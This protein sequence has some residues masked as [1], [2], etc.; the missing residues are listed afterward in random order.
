MSHPRH[1]YLYQRFATD[2][3]KRTPFA[4]EFRHRV[5]PFTQTR[6]SWETRA[7]FFDTN[8]WEENTVSWSIY[9]EV[10]E[11]MMVRMPRS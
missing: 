3:H 4:K 8:P 10:D 11:V 9:E 2:T 6:A 7:Q 1:N 5:G